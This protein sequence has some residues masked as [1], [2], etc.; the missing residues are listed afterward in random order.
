[1]DSEESRRCRERV[2][3]PRVMGGAPVARS[4]ARAVTMCLALGIAGRM[5]SAQCP[6][7]SAAPCG[8]KPGATRAVDA[9]RIAILPF[10]VSGAPELA[11]LREGLVELLSAHFNGEVGPQSVEPGE[12]LSAWRKARA[13]PEPAAQSAAVRVAREIGAGQVAY[14]S[15]VGTAR[16]FSVTTAIL[17]VPGGAAVIPVVQVAGTLDSLATAVRTLAT[18]LLGHYAGAV[19]VRATDPGTENSLAALAFLGGMAASRAHRPQEASQL[20]HRAIHLDS[21]FT[22]AAYRLAMLSAMWG[23]SGSRGDSVV[24]RRLWKERSRLSGEQ[25]M[26]LEAVADS[27]GLLSRMAALPRLQRILPLLPESAEAWDLSGDHFYHV[28]ALLGYEDWAARA[29]A[30]FRRGAALDS[31]LATALGM[32]GHYH[33]TDLA[34]ID[35]DPRAHARYAK[36]FSDHRVRYQSAI[37]RGNAAAIRD[38]RLAYVR[39]AFPRARYIVGLEGLFWPPRELDSLLVELERAVTT[40]ETRRRAA[41]NTAFAASNL[42]RP[43]MAADALWRRYGADTS[44]VLFQIL[45]FAESD[46]VAAERSLAMLARVSESIRAVGRTARELACNAA[47]SRLRRADTTGAAA[48]LRVLRPEGGPGL[49]EV[50]SSLHTPAE[51]QAGRQAVCGEVLRGVLGSLAGSDIALRRADSLMRVMPMD[52]CDYWNYDLGVA[53]ARRGEYGAAAAAVR[54]QWI[55][56]SEPAPRAAISLLQEGRWSALAADTSAAIQAYRRFIAWR[57]NPEPALVPQRDSARA[58]LAVL[59]KTY[60][61][62]PATRRPGRH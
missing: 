1:M 10:R 35:A 55:G 56:S 22:L 27:G 14:S 31:A 29:S 51:N 20:F 42:G 59:E 43:R 61:K 53:F 8:P 19:R 58:E 60:R 33:L 11:F 5:A 52:C 17:R 40:D 41:Y 4:V 62:P 13:G 45:T 18:Q 36:E 2:V 34:F 23:P 49:A 39:E 48:I 25:R 54:R 12:V 9:N 3:P 21:A 6:D 46:S 30:A 37:L 24:W 38:A 28:G 26:L 47:L 44:A 16:G 7:G 15:V 50:F 57:E 32:S